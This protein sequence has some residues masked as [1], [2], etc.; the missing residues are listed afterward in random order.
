MWKTLLK[1]RRK[2]NVSVTLHPCR[3]FCIQFYVARIFFPPSLLCTSI[4]ILVLCIV[5]A[6]NKSVRLLLTIRL[7]SSSVECIKGATVIIVAIIVVA[8]DSGCGGGDRRR[9][10]SLFLC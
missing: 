8:N 3:P 5:L 2:K 9:A 4:S 6:I 7:L 1:G 10:D